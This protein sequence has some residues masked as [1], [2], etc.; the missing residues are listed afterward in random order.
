MGLHLFLEARGITVNTYNIHVGAVFPFHDVFP[1]ARAILPGCVYEFFSEQDGYD[2]LPFK[3]VQLYV[4]EYV[5]DSLIWVCRYCNFWCEVF[6]PLIM[7]RH[8]CVDSV[9]IPPGIKTSFRQLVRDRL[10][11]HMKQLFD[12]D[13]E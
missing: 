3:H 7:E 12:I 8:L 4:D 2:F 9:A 5:P 6:D 1:R 11:V 13:I 10:Y